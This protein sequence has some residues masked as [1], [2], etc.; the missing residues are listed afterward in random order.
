M[1]R[2]RYYRSTSRE[3]SSEELS[4]VMIR[5]AL[6]FVGLGL[7]YSYFTYRAYFKWI[8]AG[9]VVF[10]IL[11]TLGILYLIELKKKHHNDRIMELIKRMK[12]EGH[13]QEIH[14][15]ILRFGDCRDKKV[16][17]TTYRNYTF[18]DNRIG[19]LKAKFLERGYDLQPGEFGEILEKLVEER[20]SNLT[21]E[22]VTS[23]SKKFSSLNGTEF[24][25]L[26]V[27]LY[28][29]MGFVVEH[30]GHTGD[31]GGDLVANRNGERL[32]VQAKRYE[33]TVGNKAVQEAVAARAHYD[34]HKTAVVTNS[35]FTREAVDLARSNS[36]SLVPR[37]HLQRMLLDYLKESWN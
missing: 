2:R 14:N 33:A 7:L 3:D 9:A 36:V 15:F 11:V 17:T 4:E 12:N 23:V 20:E 6:A 1:A 5:L 19:D 30:V 16:E 24:E 18:D 37:D 31:Q 34:C 10:I 27:R 25:K 32:L 35:T 21:V 8:I 13:L 26:L 29:A 28:T 22:S